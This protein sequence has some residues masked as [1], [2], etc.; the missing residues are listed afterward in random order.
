MAEKET[1]LQRAKAKQEADHAHQDSAK[2]AFQAKPGTHGVDLARGVSQKETQ[3]ETEDHAK[4]AFQATEGTHGVDVARGIEKEKA[5]MKA[6]KKK[7]ILG[8]KL[9][10]G[11]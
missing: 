5:G 8:R 11:Q 6:E 10:S 4:K 2:K 9:G 1:D 3:H 7:D